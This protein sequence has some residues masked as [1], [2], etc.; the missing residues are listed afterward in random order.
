[1]SSERRGRLFIVSA[2]SGAGKTTVVRRMV[3]LTP[4]IAVSR[5]YTSRSIRAGEVAG[6][7]YTYVSA[8]RFIELRD[9]G[10]FLE[11]AE[12]FGD[13]YGTGRADTVRHLETGE[14]LVLVID[15]QGA[16]KVRASGVPNVSVF[17]LPPSLAVP[18]SPP[19]RAG[20]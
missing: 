18:R 17:L 12:V 20:A 9:A 13:L 7:D 4:R 1:M 16:E 19:P 14:D 5:S 10:G 8:E 3:A 11:W 6:V 15:V 2:P